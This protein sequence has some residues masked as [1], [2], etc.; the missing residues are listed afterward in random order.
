MYQ[1]A[2]QAYQQQQQQAQQQKAGTDG[3]KDPNVVDAEFEV[4]NDEKKN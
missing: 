1:Q 2:A 3:G 4:K